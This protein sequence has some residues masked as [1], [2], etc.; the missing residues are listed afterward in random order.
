[1]KFHLVSLNLGSKKKTVFTPTC[2]GEMTVHKGSVNDIIALSNGNF[3]TCSS[4]NVSDLTRSLISTHH[5]QL[6]IL[7]R[8]AVYASAERTRVAA[9][10]LRLQGA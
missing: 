4:D 3:V 1:M 2:I 6:V 10:M 8:N 9:E 5:V 7:W